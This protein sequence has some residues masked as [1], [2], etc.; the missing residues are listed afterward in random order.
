MKIGG[1]GGVAGDAG[2]AGGAGIPITI[3]FIEVGP[4]Q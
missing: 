2:G 4:C 1:G 3:A